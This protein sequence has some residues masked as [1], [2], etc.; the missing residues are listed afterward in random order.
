MMTGQMDAEKYLTCLRSI[1]KSKEAANKF[2]S[3]GK[4][5]LAWKARGICVP[6]GIKNAFHQGPQAQ[7]N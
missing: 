6:L 4:S 7:E 1:K 5:A 2:F 3:S